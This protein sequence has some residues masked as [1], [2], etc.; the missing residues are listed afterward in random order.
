MV[1]TGNNRLEQVGST[2]PKVWIFQ[3]KTGFSENEFHTWSVSIKLLR[4]ASLERHE[5]SFFMCR[6]DGTRSANCVRSRKA[7]KGTTHTL[8]RNY[9]ETIQIYIKK[10]RNWVGRCRCFVTHLTTTSTGRL[11]YSAETIGP[12]PRAYTQTCAWKMNHLLR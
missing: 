8:F 1:S 11:L 7:D 2:Y 5:T 9:V 6:E 10:I 3:L 4:S 12:P